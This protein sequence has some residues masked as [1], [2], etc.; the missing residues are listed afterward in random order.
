MSA[1]LPSHVLETGSALAVAVAVALALLR[2]RRDPVWRPRLA[3][4]F[5]RRWPALCLG[6]VTLYA[7]VAWLDMVSWIDGAV[8]VTAPLE[9]REPRS[10]LDRAFARVVGVPEYAFRERSYSAPRAG[11]DFTDASIA[12]RHRHWFGTT[13]TGYDTLYKVLKGCKPALVIGTLPLLFALPLALVFGIAAGWWGRR[14]DDLIVYVYSTVACVPHLLLMIAIVSALGRGLPQIATGLGVLGWVGLCRLV[15]AE[16]LKLREMDYVRAA[17]CLGQTP[18]SILRRHVL[19]NL[20][21]LVLI[22]A[23]LAFSGLVLTESIL[24]Y[25]GVGLDNS[26]GAMVNHARN[27]LSQDPPVWWNI[28]FASGAIF[29]LV[30]SV[31]G[32]GDALREAFDPRAHP[33]G[34]A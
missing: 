34:S 20:A 10:L 24:S 26:W 27:E 4:A 16:T 2:V 1:G 9:A 25:L 19:P 33:E 17:A 3:G 22:S 28:T 7:L 13:Q 8:P 18:W 14:L 15:R 32:V 5:R 12:L 6:T 21:H 31:N 29:F 23:V 11:T 30:L